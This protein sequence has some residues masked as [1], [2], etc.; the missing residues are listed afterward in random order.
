[1]SVLR[2]RPTA[3]G[4]QVHCTPFADTLWGVRAGVFDKDDVVRSPARSTFVEQDGFSVGAH[5][6]RPGPIEPGDIPLYAPLETAQHHRHVLRASVDQHSSRRINVAQFH[7]AG[8]LRYRPEMPGKGDSKKRS[9]D[10]GSRRGKPYFPPRR[11]P[12]QPCYRT[13]SSA[14]YPRLFERIHY[15]YS[16]GIVHRYGVFN[17]C[18]PVTRWGNAQIVEPRRGT[19]YGLPSIFDGVIRTVRGNNSEA[20]IPAPVRLLG[21]LGDNV[22]RAVVVCLRFEQHLLT[23]TAQ[24]KEAD[25]SG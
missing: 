2:E 11:M 6:D 1:M 25:F 5:R 22:R 16:A 15:H 21:S 18:N 12:G 9:F 7:A 14:E 20:A 13:P 19:V 24:G 4:R 3:V 17:E 8:H 23:V 10:S